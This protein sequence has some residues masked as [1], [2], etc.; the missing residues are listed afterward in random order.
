MGDGRWKEDNPPGV[1]C[2]RWLEH[3]GHAVPRPLYGLP[4]LAKADRIIITE[5]EKAADAARLLGFTSTTSAG[6]SKASRK[7]DWQPLAGKTCV[8]LPDNDAAGEQYANAVAS[9]LLKLNPQP[10]VRIVALPG[11]EEGQDLVEFLDDRDNRQSADVAEEINILVEAAESCSTVQATT[12]RHL[13]V[14]NMAEVDPRPVQW[15]WTGYFPKGMFTLLGGDPGL[16]K[17][18]FM[19]A[20]AAGLTRG[21]SVM[22]ESLGEPVGVTILSSEDSL[23]HTIA[24]RLIAADAER[25]RVYV[26]RGTRTDGGDVD[27]FTLAEDLQSLTEHITGTNTQLLIIDPLSAHLGD[28][29]SHNDAALRKVLTPLSEWADRHSV[30]VVGIAHLNKNSGEGSPLYRLNGSIANVAAARMAFGVVEHP[31]KNGRCVLACIKANV[32]AKPQP[33]CFQI[34]QALVEKCEVGVVAGLSVFEGDPEELW[35]PKREP[36]L[37]EEEAEERQLWVSQQ[38]QKRGPSRVSCIEAAGEGLYTR[39]QIRKALQA[40]KAEN[41]K[42]GFTSGAAWLWAMPGAV[43]PDTP[44][45]TWAEEELQ[46]PDAEEPPALNFGGAATNDPY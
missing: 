4:E 13:I 45:P 1:A 12:G 24:P 20:V 32:A 21:E 14:S 2:C 5:G 38:L 40:I 42:V 28:V 18:S 41:R 22:G 10:Q 17:S 39:S 37:A 7:T 27:S 25:S 44:P 34:E 35:Q 23:H 43:F 16:G 30:A 9:E 36:T 29:Q 26:I 15:L 3:R 33:I 11:L 8:I 31:D 19:L 6:G 46:T